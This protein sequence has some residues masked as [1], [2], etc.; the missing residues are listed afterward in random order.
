MSREKGRRGAKEDV[1]FPGSVV[2]KCQRTFGL[3]RKGIWSWRGGRDFV[4]LSCVI[5]LCYLGLKHNGV[6][7]S[8]MVFWHCFFIYAIFLGVNIS[9][10]IFIVDVA[11]DPKKSSTL[12]T[13]LFTWLSGTRGT[14]HST[15]QATELNCW[16]QPVGGGA[17]GA[18]Q[19]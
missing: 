7:N 19:K 10:M 16:G 5:S 17:V 3:E 14:A 6:R 1:I 13:S 18:F 11:L 12:R 2:K 8:V 9:S 15:N 4:F